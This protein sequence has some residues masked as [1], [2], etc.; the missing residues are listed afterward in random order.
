MYWRLRVALNF[1]A[2][3]RTLT[4]QAP[5]CCSSRSPLLGHFCASKSR[6]RS[7]SL[8]VWFVPIFFRRH[9]FISIFMTV[10][11]LYK[12]TKSEKY[13]NETKYE[14]PEGK[15]ISISQ[16]YLLLFNICVPK[17]GLFNSVKTVLSFSPYKYFNITA[18]LRHFIHYSNN[19]THHCWHQTTNK[20][21]VERTCLTNTS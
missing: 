4:L 6:K 13:F 17:F 20:L 15:N 10:E 5:H 21:V 12:G 9:M 1:Y 8:Q 19:R 7:L 2:A 18:N 16:L 3:P 11:N 14:K